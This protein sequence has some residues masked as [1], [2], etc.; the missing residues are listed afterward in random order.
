MTQTNVVA[1]A[2]CAQSDQQMARILDH[3]YAPPEPATEV[4]ALER[5]TI[6]KMLADLEAGDPIALTADG[7]LVPYLRAMLAQPK[8]ELWAMHSVGPGEVWPMLSKEDAE[9]HAKATVERCEQIG[10]DKGWELGTITVNVIPSPFEPAEHLETIAEEQT[11]E[12]ER[13]RKLA[14]RYHEQR[15]ELLV[16]I[17]A[18]L[19]E[20]DTT[21]AAVLAKQLTD[22]IT[23]ESA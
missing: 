23:K 18:L 22:K 17:A 4:V 2:P 1:L 20:N 7:R 21:P 6:V 8:R 16:A 12:T 19:D 9:K 10:R 15:D 13:V 11:R 3:F 14:I 5:L